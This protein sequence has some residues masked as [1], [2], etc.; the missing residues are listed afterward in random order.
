MYLDVNST[1]AR[2]GIHAE[3]LKRKYK[4]AYPGTG[5]MRGTRFRE[6]DLDALAMNI[7]L[8]AKVV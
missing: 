6:E 5:S 2:L 8:L 4:A 7:G 1:A 3:T